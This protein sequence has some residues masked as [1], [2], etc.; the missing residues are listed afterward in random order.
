MIPKLLVGIGGRQMSGTTMSDTM[1][2]SASDSADSSFEM[3]IIVSVL[4]C[5]LLLNAF[6]YFKLSNLETSAS[7]SG[8][9]PPVAVKFSG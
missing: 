1:S 5:L 7:L 8:A 6:L 9:Y 3:K 4:F 2:E